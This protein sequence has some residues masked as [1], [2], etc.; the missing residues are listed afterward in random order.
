M[1]RTITGQLL[2]VLNQVAGDKMGQLQ[3]Q[4]TGVRKEEDDIT[5][6]AHYVDFEIRDVEETTTKDEVR[7]KKEV[8]GQRLR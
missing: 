3:G 8:D 4:Q 1:N 2:F 7:E 5:S 6:K